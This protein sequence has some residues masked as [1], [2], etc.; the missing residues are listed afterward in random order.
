MTLATAVFE[1]FEE[2][3]LRAPHLDSR[4]LAELLGV[5]EGEIQAARLGQGVRALALTACDLAMMLPRLGPLLAVTHARHATLR[6]HIAHC[7]IDVGERHA[8]LAHG[9]TLAMEMLLSGWYWV[10]LSHE[11]AAPDQE[12]TPCLQ[13]FNRFGQAIH[14]LYALEPD[15][16]AWRALTFRTTLKSPAF[17][18]GIEVLASP[19]PQC[20]PALLAQWRGLRT[21]RAFHRML[22]RHRLRRID[23]NRAVEG[24][25]SQR[26]DIN[27]FIMAMAAACH[28]RRATRVSL[29]RDGGLH[30]HCARFDYLAP[31]P[32]HRL[33]LEGDTL[34]LSLDSLALD[35]AWL[36]TR[37]DEQGLRTLLEAFDERGRLIAALEAS[38][39]QGF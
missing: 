25:F 3:R 9:D 11:Q 33:Q 30:R 12:V 14:R 13:I 22:S 21:E 10:C 38:R 16:P 19:V 27:R 32:D 34:T 23:A 26:I 31:G 35:E 1:A 24:H 29:A 28:N 8:Y 15:H 37:P 7:R 6:S 4:Q 5:S 18:R 39:S 36:V 2:A 20:L 17:T